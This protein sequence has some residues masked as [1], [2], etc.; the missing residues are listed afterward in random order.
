M[1]REEAKAN[2]LTK[3]KGEGIVGALAATISE[4]LTANILYESDLVEML[5]K[6]RS[7]PLYEYATTESGRSDDSTPPP[8]GNGW[9]VNIDHYGGYYKHDNYVDNYWRR[10]KKHALT[11]DVPI[12]DLPEVRIAKMDFSL[13]ILKL[14]A[15]YPA[16]VIAGGTGKS[17]TRKAEYM[18][19][20]TSFFHGNYQPGLLG[21]SPGVMEFTSARDWE[22]FPFKPRESTTSTPMYIFLAPQEHPFELLIDGQDPENNS[23]ARVRTKG[24]KFGAWEQIVGQTPLP[25]HPTA[26]ENLTEYI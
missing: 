4:A 15:A 23:W 8:P 3:L 11:D 10:E 5:H 16:G 19:G 25:F 9:E 24:G 7:H 22:K 12:F 17:L 1:N 14:R 2:I 21:Y 13:V 26:W 20:P 6:E 18:G